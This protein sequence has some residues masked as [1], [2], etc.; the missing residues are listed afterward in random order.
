ME[1]IRVVLAESHPIGGVGRQIM[2]SLHYLFH[3]LAPDASLIEMRLPAEVRPARARP[4][5]APATAAQ[6]LVLRDDTNSVYVFGL[7]THVPMSDLT[8]QGALQSIL[9]ALPPAS[10]DEA[11]GRQRIVARLA[12]H[13]AADALQDLPVLT[14]REQEVLQQLA[15]GKADRQIADDLGIKPRT[16]RYHLQNIYAKLGVKQRSEAIV[17]A[18]RVGASET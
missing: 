13:S 1:A 7:L 2:A 8:E 6:I 5:H 4:E 15:L 3:D 9:A 18:I 14:A 16:V 11:G 10:S 12:G 17:W